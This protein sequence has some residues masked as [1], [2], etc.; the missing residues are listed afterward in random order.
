MLPLIVR[1]YAENIYRRRSNEFPGMP[2]CVAITAMDA[3]F[4]RVH[5]IFQKWTV[6]IGKHCN[7]SNEYSVVKMYQTKHVAI[8]VREKN[9]HFM[10]T[11]S[12]HFAIFVTCQIGLM[13]I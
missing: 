10:F 8:I 7:H 11:S 2:R 5:T 6:R 9:I 4:M 3:P 12:I 13:N 1:N